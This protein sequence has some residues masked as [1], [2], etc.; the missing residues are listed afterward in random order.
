MLILIRLL[1][2]Y[3]T[4]VRNSITYCVLT[5]GPDIQC[6]L[7][8]TQRGENMSKRRTIY[9]RINQQLERIGYVILGSDGVTID[10]F[11]MDPNVAQG[12]FLKDL[13]RRQFE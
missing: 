9:W 8:D 2:T 10:T 3:V 6:M 12:A 1:I 11:V 7:S 5:V 13:I 4:K